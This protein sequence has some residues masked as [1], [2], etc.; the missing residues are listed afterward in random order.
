MQPQPFNNPVPLILLFTA[1]GFII[2]AV[3]AYFLARNESRKQQKSGELDLIEERNKRFQE[4]AGL[5]RDRAGGKLAVWLGNRM[6]GD[7][8][9]V[10][11][12]DRQ[13]LE[14]AG[15]ELLAWLGAPDKPVSKPTELPAPARVGTGPLTARMARP[16]PPEEHAP[17]LGELAA[18]EDP[19]KP[20]KPMSIVEQINDILQGMLKDTPLASRSI[21]LVED[22]REGVVVLV[23][24]ERY[25]GV[26]SVPD[27]DIKTALRRAAGEWERRAGKVRH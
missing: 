12:A 5:W 10:D 18:A 25:K 16:V 27:Q 21:K 11:A 19:I 17:G 7:P 8:N 24:L 14:E 9:L 20:P 6:V 22:P 3:L 26:D 13:R 1:I 23:G 15:R 2:G 4:I